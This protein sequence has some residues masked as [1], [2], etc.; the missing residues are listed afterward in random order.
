M[1]VNRKIGT[2]KMKKDKEAAKRIR[3][4]RGSLTQ[5]EF[6]KFLHVAQ[7]MV[8]AW[9]AGRE[10]PASAD[11]WI[12]F[13]E[14]AGWPDCFWFWQRAGLVPKTLLAAV[15]KTL[16]EQ[17]EERAAPLVEGE[18]YRIP[19]FRAT[20][21]GRE[22]TGNL[23]PLPARFIPHPEKTICLLL[24]LESAELADCPH[25]LVLVDTSIE[26]T[27]DIRGIS[28]HVIVLRYAP[29]GQALLGSKGLYMGRARIE[30]M[31]HSGRRDWMRISLKLLSLKPWTPTWTMLGMYEDPEGMRGIPYE[32]D[33]AR[34]LRLNEILRKVGSNFPLA[35]GVQII[36]SAVGRLTGHLGV[37]EA[38]G[39]GAVRIQNARGHDDSR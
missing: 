29:E 17:G 30:L 32:D 38:E 5:V 2:P 7:P 6:A 1:K 16:N 14:I 10:L 34:S 36:G 20:P 35:E 4:L 28:E 26:G 9:E 3:S 37:A 13:G 19:E 15:Q 11:L 24:E 21:Q 23:I 12:K 31:Q 39:A 27:R 22:A 8:S 18:V 25:G 33:E